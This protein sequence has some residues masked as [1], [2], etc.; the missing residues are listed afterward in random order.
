MPRPKRKNLRLRSFDYTSSGAYFVTLCAV[1][2]RC[3][4]GAVR[5]DFVSL[6]GL[7]RIVENCWRETPHHLA[8]AEL[9]AFVVM[10]NNLQAIVFLHARARHASPLRLGTV[11]RLLQV[12]R[13]GSRAASS[14]SA[15][16][17]IE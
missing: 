6:S 13:R 9:D 10:P 14:G 16:I 8:G 15:A 17:T 1:R 3:L 5:D 2:R 7:G 11:V 4:F 12:S